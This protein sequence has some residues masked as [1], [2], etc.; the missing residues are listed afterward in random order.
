MAVDK[1][2]K[3]RW[4]TNWGVADMRMA[5][6]RFRPHVA[7]N[8]APLVPIPELE[9]WYRRACEEYGVEPREVGR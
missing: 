1:P 9:E 3:W 8:G 4:D 2:M 6:Q 7:T 5:L